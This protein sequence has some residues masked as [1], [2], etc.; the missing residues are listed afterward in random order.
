M[1]V[2]WLVGCLAV[3]L[4]LCLFVWLSVF[5]SL[6]WVVWIAVPVAVAVAAP[7][8]LGAAGPTA[9]PFASLSLLLILLYS[10]LCWCVQVFGCVH[11][12]GCMYDCFLVACLVVTFLSVGRSNASL[13]V[14]VWSFTCSWFVV[15]CQWSVVSC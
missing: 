10:A 15:C 7:V 9:L 6:V 5:G 12:C 1:C 3:L 8:A 2:G 13:I 4:F 14:M 11:V